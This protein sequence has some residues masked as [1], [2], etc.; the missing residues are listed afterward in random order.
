[1]RGNSAIMRFGGGKDLVNGG[2]KLD[3]TVKGESILWV[4]DMH[5]LE[6]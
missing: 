2:I 3:G 6:L 5:L 4:C 1:M